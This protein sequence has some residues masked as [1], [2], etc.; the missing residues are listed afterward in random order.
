MVDVVFSFISQL[1]MMSI[2]E[3]DVC[4]VEFYE[5]NKTQLLTDTVLK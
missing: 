5:V 2:L 4:Y 3:C 1:V